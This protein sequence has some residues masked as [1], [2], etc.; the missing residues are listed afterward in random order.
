MT[1]DIQFINLTDLLSSNKNGELDYAESLKIIRKVATE[2]KNSVQKNMLVDLRNVIS[3][4]TTSEIYELVSELSSHREQF[5]K[6][7][8]LLYGSNFDAEKIRFLEMCANNRGFLINAFTDYDE[9]VSW[10]TKTNG[11]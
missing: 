10:L 9:A 7:I 4:V 3:V 2:N 5:S 6:K 8:A 1:A 11:E